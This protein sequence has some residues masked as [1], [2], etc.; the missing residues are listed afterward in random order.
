MSLLFIDFHATNGSNGLPIRYQSTDFRLTASRLYTRR[1][2]QLSVDRHHSPQSSAPLSPNASIQ[3][4]HLN[5]LLN[6]LCF[7]PFPLTFELHHGSFHS[8]FE[9]IER[10]QKK[11]IHTPSRFLSLEFRISSRV[12]SSSPI[13]ER[14]PT[15]LI[16]PFF[17]WP[18]FHPR[19]TE[20]SSFPH[21]MHG[22]S[23]KEKC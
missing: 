6:T 18:F 3:Q 7:P 1:P 21:Q 11:Q 4:N 8:P 9:S 14:G 12:E 17:L 2:R 22:E 10:Q 13:F 16:R 5:R 20:L 19:T 23:T 15:S